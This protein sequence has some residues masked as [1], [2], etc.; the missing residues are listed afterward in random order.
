[1]TDDADRQ[2]REVLKEVYAAWDAND[3]DAFAEPG[4]A[5]RALET[6]VLSRQDGAWRVQAFHNCPEQGNHDAQ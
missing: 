2:V 3:A 4:A 5:S 6:W 1:M